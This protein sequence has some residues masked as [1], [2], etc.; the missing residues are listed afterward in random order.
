MRLAELF[1]FLNV[2]LRYGHEASAQIVFV[3]RQEI[4]IVF[5]L[6]YNPEVVWQG[7][8]F[9][10]SVIDNFSLVFGIKVLIVNCYIV[11]RGTEFSVALEIDSYERVVSKVDFDSHYAAL[12]FGQSCLSVSTSTMRSTTHFGSGS[13]RD[14]CVL[15][16]SQ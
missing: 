15:K 13:Q 2:F 10:C 1:N 3:L 12:F 14:G 9:L 11:S 16:G 4:E 5:V 6:Q 7:K 8:K